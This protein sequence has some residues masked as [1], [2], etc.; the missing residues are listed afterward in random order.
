M[1]KVIELFAGIGSQCQALKNIGAD[2]EIVGISE[3]DKYAVQSYELLHGK[4]VNFGDI[5]KIESLPKADLWTYSFPCQDISLAGKMKGFTE[6]SNTRSSLLWQVGRL[7]SKAKENG[8]LPKYLLMENVKNIV[9]ETMIDN[10]KKWIEILATFGYV[11]DYQVLNSKDYG[12]PQNRERCFMVSKLTDD[13][14]W[15][16]D[17]PSKQ[18]S[19]LKLKDMLENEPVDEKYYLKSN[20]AQKL[21]EIM[22]DKI[23]QTEVVDATINDPKI[24]TVANCITARY[25][26]GIQTQKSIGYVVIIPVAQ[27]GDGVIQTLNTSGND[28]GVVVKDITKNE[29]KIIDTLKNA[30]V[31]KA[32]LFIDSY[33]KI[34]KSDT[35]GTITTRVDASNST[36]IL[37]TSLSVRKL[38]PKECWRL[39][40]WKDEDI[41]K[42]INKL[43]NTQ[44]YKQAGNGIVVQVLERI[45]ENII[46]EQEEDEI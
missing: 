13:W 41:D 4:V 25:D 16:F 24:K 3:I 46:K 11:S 5:S 6:D 33:N 9:S 28:V 15:H 44:L 14:M 10:F 26:A 27:E 2:F 1:I 18:D 29:Q 19:Q 39:M 36:F 30:D 8:T 34:A 45:F 31:T 12:I 20:Y 42:V 35:T 37:N 7:L 23:Q 32:P 21:Q 22:K 43:S 17:F 40:G 38:T